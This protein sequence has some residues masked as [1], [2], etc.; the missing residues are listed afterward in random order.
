MP[1]S[2]FKMQTIP[3]N[4]KTKTFFKNKESEPFLNNY[5]LWIP[6]CLISNRKLVANVR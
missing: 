4:V 6:L 1:K 5:F 3:N 2:I